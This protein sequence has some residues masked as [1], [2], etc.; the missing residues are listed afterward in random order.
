[1]KKWVLVVDD[2]AGVRETVVDLL[3]FGGFRVEAVA[4]GRLALETL[5]RAEALPALL[6]V[7][8]EMPIMSGWELIAELRKNARLAAIPYVIF[9]A[10]GCGDERMSELDAEACVPKGGSTLE[11][12]RVVERCTGRVPQAAGLP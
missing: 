10:L 7:D 3:T 2:D 5:G 4:D 8:L 9:S 11:L 6:V 12:L 1:M